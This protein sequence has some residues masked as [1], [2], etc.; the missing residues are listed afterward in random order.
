MKPGILL[1][2]LFVL[3]MNMALNAQKVTVRATAGAD[4]TD[5]TTLNG[6]FSA[7]NLGTHKG[8]ITVKIKQSTTEG[9]SAVLNASGS[10]SASY[11]SVNIYP[12]VSGLTVSGNYSGALIDLYGADHVTIDGRVNAAGSSTD[13]T[14][15]NT[16]TNDGNSSTIK[17]NNDAT[18][19]T[20]KYCVIKGSAISS[21]RGILLFSNT[22]TA[23]GN[24]HNTIDHNEITNSGGYRPVNTIASDGNSSY[25]NGYNTISNNN[26]HDVLNPNPNPAFIIKL[27]IGGDGGQSY[28]DAWTISGNSFYDTQDYTITTGNNIRII[29]IYADGGNGFNISNNYF[30]GSAPLCGGTWNKTTGANTF[31]LMELRVGYTIPTEIQGNT[32]KNINFKNSNNYIWWGLNMQRGKINIGTT[33]GNCYGASDG[34]GSVTFTA[35]GN[36][37]FYAMYFQSSDVNA[38]N[39]IIGSITTANTSSANATNFYGIFFA[40]NGNSC[41]LSNN[42]IGSISTSNSIHATSVSTT[43]AQKVWGIISCNGNSGTVNVINNTVANLTNGTTNS[44]TTVYGQMYGIFINQPTAIVSGNLIHHL[45]I[46]NANAASDCDPG[47]LNNPFISAAGIAFV[48]RYNTSHTISGN[49]IYNISNSYASFTGHV[50]GIYFYGQP[51]ASSVTGNLISELNVSSGSNAANIDGIKIANGVAT[52]SNNIIILGG[53]TTTNLYGI[54]DGNSSGTSN[55]YFNSVYLK[56]SPASGSLKSAGLYNSTTANTRNYRNNIFFNARSNSGASG[57]HYAMYIANTGGN[58]TCNYNDYYVTGTG[59]TLGYYGGDK[60]AVPI[61]SGVTGN[62]AQSLNLNPSFAN[63]GGTNAG[64]YIPSTLL[65]AATG[66]GVTTD[67][68]GSARSGS[69]P[70]MGAWEKSNTLTWTGSSSTDWSVAENWDLNSLPLASSNVTIPSA[71][72]N[73]PHI[74]QAVASPATCNSLTIQPGAVVTIDPAKALT[75]NGTLT[76]SA[77]NSG[78]VISSDENG[79]GSLIQASSA[80]AATVQRYITGSATLTDNIYHFVSIPVYKANPTSSLFLGSYLYNLDPTQAEPTNNN[81]YGKWV[82]L[83]EATT[84]P[85]SC[86]SGYMIYYP[87]PSKTYTFTGNLNTGSFSP[88]VSYGGTYTFNLVP[89]PYPSAINWGASGGWLKSNI[90]ATAWIWNRLTGNY[91][92]LSGNSYVPAGQAFIVMA[93]G[94]PVLT[95][96]NSACIHNTQPFY[97][98]S[99]ANT[100]MITVQ[101]NNYY[102]ETFVGFDSSAGPGF[103]PQLDGF[104]MWGLE[105]APQL[106]TEKGT[107]RLSINR[108]PPPSGSLI[109]P[110]DFKTSHAGQVILNVSGI[111]S[112]D[113]SLPL[114]LQDHLNGSVTDLRQNSSYE[115]A[116][117]PANSENRFSLIFGYPE[118]IGATVSPQGKA[119]ISNGMVFLDIPFMQGHPAHITVYDM[120]GQLIRIQEKSLEGIISIEAP[121][122]KGIYIVSVSSAGRNF[123]TKV[124]NK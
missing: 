97:K 75:V 92:T 46:A 48:S 56:G 21:D 110:L 8:I 63:A 74:T 12:T 38:Q 118:G 11:T 9:A 18:Y 81:Y 90:G 44:S 34:T 25:P 115:F 2:L 57:K 20:V 66:T 67:Y 106:W 17:F 24:S 94:S 121:V 61:V 123:I 31:S 89:N 45:T 6:A 49:T 39:N 96:N 79:T 52:F 84:T 104:K 4:S 82:N 105:E 120:L 22:A 113:S 54:Y 69:S 72:A 77:G 40:S 47:N 73:Q 83:G 23:A 71:P 41:S 26:I 102:D 76:N 27:G 15:T 68:G 107:S 108:L 10:G 70:E 30:G 103:D 36:S 5:Y 55:V 1:V 78:L 14:I 100:L 62:D 111:E 19:N 122:A 116:H 28:N 33:A 29:Y 59:G 65:P 35:N 60:S 101:S 85:L 51:T 88:E 16:R 50:A 43:D 124:I 53:S 109:V 37:A 117:H 7:I 3:S 64:N 58:L 95:M 99:Q 98:S 112:F 32:I 80:V 13:M 86:L 91:T 87:G 42:T 93:S 114:R 119:F